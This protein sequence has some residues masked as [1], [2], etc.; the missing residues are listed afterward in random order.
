MCDPVD[1]LPRVDAH[2]CC[3]TGEE[4]LLEAS[5]KPDRDGLPLQVTDCTDLVS[6][7]QLEAT[8]V[9]PGQEDDGVPCVYLHNEW[10]DEGHGNVDLAGGQS[11]EI[12]FELHVLYVDEPLAYHESF[13]HVLGRHTD[14]R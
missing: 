8:G 9:N 13:G 11:S 10:C 7:E 2:M 3:D 6:A 14:S 12:A 1:V 4:D 5:L